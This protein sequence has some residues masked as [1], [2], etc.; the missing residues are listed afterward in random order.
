MK[1]IIFS[2][3][4]LTIYMDTN[5]QDTENK[6]FATPKEVVTLDG[7]SIPVYDFNGLRPM[8]ESSDDT[9]LVVNFWATWCRPCVEE[10]PHF[11]EAAEELK[12]QPVRFVYVSLD[13]RKNLESGVIPFVRNRGMNGSVV[14]LHDP[15]ADRW[16]GQV[17]SGWSGA[18]PATLFV[19]GE[20]RIFREKALT[21]DELIQIIHSLIL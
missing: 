4:L 5:A 17:D 2:L 12:G 8:L 14:L 18:I 1:A 21:K 13:F 19:S 3:I 9:I 6:S 10:I 20:R 15:D 11:L 16:I 7:I